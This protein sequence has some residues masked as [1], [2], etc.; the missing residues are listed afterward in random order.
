MS[1]L[2]R[3]ESIRTG[4]AAAW[5]AAGIFV[6]SVAA[7]ASPLAFE[8]DAIQIERVYRGA[9]KSVTL[10]IRGNP[11]TELGLTAEAALIPGGARA[12][13]VLLRPSQPSLT[14]GEDGT[15]AVSVA[16]VTD[17]DCY[18]GPASAVLAARDAS[19]GEAR[20]SFAFEVTQRGLVVG[21]TLDFGSSHFRGT[22]RAALTLELQ[23][24]VPASAWLDW[25]ALSGDAGGEILAAFVKPATRAIELTPDSRVM[26]DI[27]IA[28][29]RGARSG[30][31]TGT[32]SV[33]A[34]PHRKDITTAIT[35]LAPSLTSSPQRIELGSVGAGN[36]TEAALEV[37][38]DG[39]VDERIEFQLAGPLVKFARPNAHLDTIAVELAGGATTIAPGVPVLATVRCAVPDGQ[40]DGAY[41]GELMVRAGAARALVPIDVVVPRPEGLPSFTID[42]IELQISVV[43]GAEGLGSIYVTSNEDDE[44]TIMAH[45]AG[46]PPAGWAVALEED[47]ALVDECSL[48]VPPR[49]SIDLPIRAALQDSRRVPAHASVSVE[50]DGVSASART[51]VRLAQAAATPGNAQQKFPAHGR[52]VLF[53][54]AVVC[55][56]VLV[57]RW[58]ARPVRFAALSSLAHVFLLALGVASP[59]QSS[60]SAAASPERAIAIQVIQLDDPF[61][62]DLASLAESALAERQPSPGD[63]AESDPKASG[64][65]G[66]PTPAGM[67]LSPSARAIVQMPTHPDAPARVAQREVQEVARARSPLAGP[68]KGR[69]SEGFD[70][71]GP[72]ALISTL[73]QGEVARAA[74][75]GEDT[76]GALGPAARS[77]AIARGE[78]TL[79]EEIPEDALAAPDAPVTSLP[80]AASRIR[81]DVSSASVADRVMQTDAPDRAELSTSAIARVGAGPHDVAAERIVTA[82]AV[83]PVVEERVELGPLESPAETPEQPVVLARPDA[84]GRGQSLARVPATEPG[85][86]PPE[87]LFLRPPT[88]LSTVS[89]TLSREPLPDVAPL[90]TNALAETF[91]DMPPAARPE[92]KEDE[93]GAQRITRARGTT[94][95]GVQGRVEESF[96]RVAPRQLDS[97][98]PAA[99]IQ[100]PGGASLSRTDTAPSRGVATVGRV[101]AVKAETLLGIIKHRG[102]WNLFPRAISSLASELPKRQ[103]GFPLQPKAAPLQ[104]TEDTLFDCTLVYLT[105]RGAP[106]LTSAGE[107]RLRTYL[108]RG[109]F[110]WVDD[111]APSGDKSFDDG[112]RGLLK[113]L[114]ADATLRRIPISHPVFASSYDLVNGYAGK[115]P[116]VGAWSRQTELTGL[117]APTGRLMGIYTRNGYGRA[118]E[119]D[120]S[121]DHDFTPPRGLTPRECRE[122]ALRVAVNIVAHRLRSSG[123]D[124]PEAG[125]RQEA[126][127]PARA[128]RY[129]GRPLDVDRT[130]PAAS[131]WKELDGG[132][133]VRVTGS[134][135]VL[136]L[137]IGTAEAEWAG[138]SRSC[139]QQIVASRAIVLDATS[140]LLGAARLSVRLRTTGGE[141][142]ESVPLYLRPG[143]NENL[144]IPLD[145][146]SFRATE[147]GWKHFDAALDRRKSYGEISFV[148]TGRDIAGTLQLARF[149]FEGWSGTE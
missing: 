134:S 94:P 38:L 69:P 109:G 83:R 41:S 122:G 35:I 57:A 79:V 78:A 13:G 74:L 133:P 45:L 68:S 92:P 1:P 121:A 23:S 117:F 4:G 65:R 18:L 3:H 145:D 86:A 84:L 71:D 140:A 131:E 112:A 139:P 21:D 19:G 67:L 75:A 118:L 116:P 39:S 6:A 142:Y 72:A 5:L 44:I 52:L 28:V 80:A 128:Y 27:E 96:T 119:L 55:V 25:S 108:A 104:A 106:D 76:F 102:D 103:P 129:R 120:P 9:A 144:R 26:T 146:S 98:L 93:S 100:R 95:A 77:G 141:L 58:N 16:V 50:F 33:L 124:L 110:I 62:D 127:D 36:S 101:R 17:I 32:L 61:G 85:R 20:A 123:Q 137:S 15:A 7:G 30:H 138:A 115:N 125:A 81:T 8:P 149:R 111:G 31:Y 82:V 12:A 29:P 132:A 48:T 24:P 53:I 60:T 42:P 63:E 130:L 70:D 46:S 114:A 89:A 88:D 43:K 2:R 14:I 37:S 56:I 135:G 73:A 126:N 64:G 136:S 51:E 87:R 11:G 49:A 105:G 113:R 22:V 54:I 107:D 47:G 147:T 97:A 59:F 66:R 34:G 148:V 40:E 143:A 10:Q 90:R 99:R 91:A